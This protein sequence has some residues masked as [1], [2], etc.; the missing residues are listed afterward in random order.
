[1]R[2]LILVHGRSQQDKDAAELKKEWIG[3]WEKGLK[4]N[5]LVNPLKD[6]DIRFPYFGNTLKQMVD[7]KDASEVVDIIVKGPAPAS[8]E[9]DFIREMVNEI[10][11][12][13][14]VAEADILAELSGKVIAKGPANWGWV[15]GIL[16][17]LDKVRPLS[18]GIVTLVTADVAKYMT[19]ATIAKKID[20]GMR[21]AILPN[22]EA[23]VVSHSLGTVVA[24]SVLMSRTGKFPAVKVPAF[25]TL[26]SP[27]AVNA[28]KSRLRPHTFPPQVGKWLNAMDPDDVVALHPLDKRHFNTGGTIKN[29]QSVDNWTN[30]QHGIVGYLDDSKVAKWI[31]DAVTSP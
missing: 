11:A 25:I 2:Q 1:M 20:D 12:F 13:E 16:A 4:A 7:G 15:Q 22:R 8:A 29:H 30:N 19:D 26:G 28:I 31:F 17:A 3:A 18:Q 5:G 10:A 14:G 23:V 9:Q 27:L 24:Y 21:S 6:E